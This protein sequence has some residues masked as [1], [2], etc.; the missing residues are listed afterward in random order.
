MQ[1]I[2]GWNWKKRRVSLSPALLE[3]GHFTRRISVVHGFDFDFEIYVQMH[4]SLLGVAVLGA[5]GCGGE[6]RRALV[7]GV[8][9]KDNHSPPTNIIITHTQ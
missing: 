7:V 1:G 5:V 6:L 2:E 9:K 3:V 8:S 4:V